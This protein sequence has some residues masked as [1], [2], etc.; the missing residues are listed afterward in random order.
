MGAYKRISPCDYTRQLVSNSLNGF[1]INWGFVQYSWYIAVKLRISNDFMRSSE[2]IK[3]SPLSTAKYSQIVP[4]RETKRSSHSREHDVM[5]RTITLTQRKIV[6][7]L[8]N[9]VLYT[10]KIWSTEN[11]GEIRICSRLNAT[12]DSECKCLKW[13]SAIC[14]GKI[15]PLM[16]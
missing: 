2:K 7:H 10:G 16:Q 6:L 9:S 5:Q 4:Y 8:N 14:W 15:R 11:N 13:C 3:I 1:Q 12:E